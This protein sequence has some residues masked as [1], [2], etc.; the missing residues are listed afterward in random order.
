MTKK[1]KINQIPL[2]PLRDVVVYPNMVIPLF[3]GRPKSIA[4][5]E[6][7]MNINNKKI[8]LVTQKSS[9][10]DDPDPENLYQ[11]GSI[12]TILQLLKLPDGTM[13]VLAEGV[14][15]AK[16]INITEENKYF[17]ADYTEIDET[18]GL[19]QTQIDAI[20][21]TLEDTFSQYVKLNKKVPPEVLSTVSGIDDISKLAD[22]IAAH[23][24][25]KL[26]EKQKVLE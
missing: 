23:M 5:L 12:A 19:N 8:L 18:L 4:A 16:I 24:T 20:S 3:V 13:K 7:S 22:S 2:L 26:D 11:I 21:R 6:D 17:L 14:S 15:R 10:V 1:T 25:L 9:E